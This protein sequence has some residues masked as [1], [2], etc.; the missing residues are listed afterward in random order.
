MAEVR[1]ILGQ[2]ALSATTLTDVYTVP[3]A[4]QTVISSVVICNRGA[5]DTTFRIA[6]AVA[7][8]VDANKQYIYYNTAV[9]AN[10]SYVATI[11]ITLSAADILR[12]YTTGSSVSVS[13]FGAEE[14]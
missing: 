6:L 14:S 12:A 8:A 4:T 2:A 7:G 1:K 13:V 11:G 10:E 5:S 3:V 9:P